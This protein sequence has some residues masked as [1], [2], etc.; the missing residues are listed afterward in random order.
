MNHKITIGIVAHV[1]SGKTT[2]VE[3][4]LYSFGTLKRLGR[5]DHQDAFLDTAK[6]EKERGITVFSKVARILDEDQEWILLDTPGHADFSAEMERSL[7]VLDYIIFVVNGKE[8]VRGNTRLLWDV[9]KEYQKPVFLFINKMDQV[10]GT[11][12]EI[13]KDLQENLDPNII[14]FTKDEDLLWEEIATTKEEL[15]KIFL[16]KNKIADE[17]IQ[18]EIQKRSLFPTYFGSALKMEGLEDFTQGLNR[19][20]TSS[21]WSEEFGARVYGIQRDQGTRLTHIKVTGGKIE[22]KSLLNGEKINE[23]RLYSGKDYE[24]VQEVSG[25]EVCSLVGLDKTFPG[26]GLGFEKDLKSLLVPIHRYGIQPKNSDQENQLI[27]ALKILEDEM[28]ELRMDKADNGEIRLQIM[29]DIL[30]EVLEELLKERFDLEVVFDESKIIYKEGVV[31][32]SIGTG[33]FEPMGHYAEVQ[34]LLEPGEPGKVTYEMGS[35]RDKVLKKDGTAVLEILKNEN[36]RGVL[37]NGELTNT[38]I[39]VL[40]AKT[41]VKHTQGGDLRQATFRALRQGL[42]MGESEILE[43]Y[44]RLEIQVGNELYGRILTDLTK[45]DARETKVNQDLNSCFFQGEIPVRFAKDYIKDFQSFTAGQGRISAEFSKY[46][47][48]GNQEEVIREYDYNPLE[49]E[50][51]PADSVFFSGGKAFIV[52]WDQVYDYAHIPL[53]K[54]EV[55]EEE[56]ELLTE[57]SVTIDE[58]EIEKILNETFYSNQKPSRKWQKKKKK[59]YFLGKEKHLKAVEKEIYL[60]DGYNM[61]YTWEELKKEA[62]IDLESARFRLLEMLSNYQGFTNRDIEVVFDAYKVK[63]LSKSYDFDN[64]KITFTT[65]GLTADQ[66]IEA[67]VGKE[68]E[69]TRVWVITSD[70]TE[71]IVA[72]GAG[73]YILS[74]RDFKKEIQQT[75]EWILDRMEKDKREL[76]EKP[77]NGLEEN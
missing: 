38:K 61:V 46:S 55:E 62:E 34:L 12:E 51:N 2:L 26:Q 73:A 25:G 20:A 59:D 35:D 10:E 56:F 27:E 28:P 72:R 67:R 9:L 68:K 48:A 54:R 39:T 18:I 23:I 65:E 63:G 76:G 16:D 47:S 70:G 74:A 36:L 15:L 45:F 42:L 22:N 31:E 3:A 40:G 30:T 53:P 21:R 69:T 19:W 77:F 6:V 33:H 52:P 60:V 37:I 4:L 64:L 41:H 8:G 75:Y 7:S 57:S 44:Q 58:L 50:N 49:D 5:V 32:P 24:R 1:D 14:D 66:Y 43:P 71:Q 17:R 11:K 13:I 29:G